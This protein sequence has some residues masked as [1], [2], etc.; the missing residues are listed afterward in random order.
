MRPGNADTHLRGRVTSRPKCGRHRSGKQRPGR[1]FQFTFI[2]FATR[3]KEQL[4]NW[5]VFSTGYNCMDFSTAVHRVPTCVWRWPG[6]CGSLRK[7]GRR[8]LLPSHIRHRGKSLIN[9]LFNFFT[10]PLMS[11]FWLEPRTSLAQVV[12]HSFSVIKVKGRSKEIGLTSLWP[13]FFD[14]C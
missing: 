8:E 13:L 5:F 11:M 9:S 12:I 14:K 2:Y 4:K 7:R 6:R 1:T 10:G 3:Y